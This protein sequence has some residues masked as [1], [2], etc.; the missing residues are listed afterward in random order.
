MFPQHLA[1]E[2]KNSNG[3]FVIVRNERKF[4]WSFLPRPAAL[5]CSSRVNN[6]NL[7]G[8]MKGSGSLAAF[9]IK[10]FFAA[11]VSFSRF[12]RRCEGFYGSGCNRL[13][14]YCSLNLCFNGVINLILPPLK[15]I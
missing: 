8:V 14:V 6:F 10:T 3:V 11:A 4:S 7:A 15:L 1:G 13:G 5:T 12:S 2:I 9:E